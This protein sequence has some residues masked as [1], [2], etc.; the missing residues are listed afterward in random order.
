MA[1]L[2]LYTKLGSLQLVHGL[3]TSLKL[4]VSSCIQ[5]YRP[6]GSKKNDAKAKL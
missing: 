3:E 1:N 2:K 6:G 4:K 5:V